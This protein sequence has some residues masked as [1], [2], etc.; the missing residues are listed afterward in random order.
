MNHFMHCSSYK[1]ETCSDWEDIFGNDTDLQIAAGLAIETRFH[2][3]EE[4][5]TKQEDGRAQDFNFTA[6]GDC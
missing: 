2:E 1:S 6:P 3:R 4:M 5:I